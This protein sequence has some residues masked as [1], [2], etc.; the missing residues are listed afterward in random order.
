M[1]IPAYPL[2]WP[3]GWPRSKGRKTAQFGKTEQRSNG[4]GSSW[5]SKTD[6]TMADAMK[7]VKIELDRLNINVAD[8][9]IVSR[10]A[11]DRPP[12]RLPCWRQRPRWR[13][14]ESPIAA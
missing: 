4:A 5:K 1:S 7:R 2:K 3:D 14:A 11:S 10:A 6:I 13:P 9:S 12:A 8:D